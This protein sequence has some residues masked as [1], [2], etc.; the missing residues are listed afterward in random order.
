MKAEAIY[1][2]ACAILFEKT[3]TD[4]DFLA[5]FPSLASLLLQEA[6]PYENA[7]RETRGQPLLEAAPAVESME[8]DI[9]YCDA[10]CRLALPYGVAAYYFQDEMD[11]YHSQDFRAR[12]ILALREAAECCGEAV[13]DCY[14][15]VPT[16]R[17]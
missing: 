2:L 16:C 6:L 3:G 12:Y 7:R 15:S 1:K 4:P 17:L 11:G 13:E 5:F 10:I 9:P 14:R 8:D